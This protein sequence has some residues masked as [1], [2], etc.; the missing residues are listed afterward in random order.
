[1]IWSSPAINSTW[2]ASSAAT[3]YYVAWTAKQEGL[4]EGLCATAC[5]L[6]GW[7]VI[8]NIVTTHLRERWIW[9]C[10]TACWL[11]VWFDIDNIVTTHL[12]GSWIWCC[13]TACWLNSWFDI[14]NIVT[15]HLRGP[16]IR[17][18][19]TACWLGSWFGTDDASATQWR[20][21]VVWNS[22]AARFLGQQLAEHSGCTA[23]I[24]WV[25]QQA[26]RHC[27][28]QCPQWW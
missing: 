19:A 10:A 28:L 23:L 26:T 6:R 14:D 7:F 9:Y 21:R 15:T 1:M 16:W 22:I 20:I 2:P 18:W 5:W 24:S 4:W 3:F 25:N 11:S 12:R 13:A 8:D 27:T 17:C